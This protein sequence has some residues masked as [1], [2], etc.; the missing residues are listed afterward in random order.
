MI[1]VVPKIH[2]TPPI[3][4]LN[5][6]PNLECMI[7]VILLFG[8]FTIYRPYKYDLSSSQ[9]RPSGLLLF[10]NLAYMAHQSKLCV[11]APQSQTHCKRARKLIGGT[12]C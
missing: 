11:K 5:I 12:G 1:S 9:A 2:W 8:L 6:S 3:Y 10:I 4:T 7:S